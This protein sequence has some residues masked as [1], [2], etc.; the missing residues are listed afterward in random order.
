MRGRLIHFS[1]AGVSRWLGGREGPET[2]RRAQWSNVESTIS[3]MR[4]THEALFAK[5]TIGKAPPCTCWLHINIGAMEG[6]DN[7][8]TL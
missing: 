3:A 2:S 5:T 1:N 7:A 4:P 8:M 6:T